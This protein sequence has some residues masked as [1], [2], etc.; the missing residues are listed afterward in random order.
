MGFQ[1]LVNQNLSQSISIPSQALD[2]ARTG[3]R[4]GERP[5]PAN[6][7]GLRGIDGISILSKSKSLS[8]YINPLTS[9]RLGETR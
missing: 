7:Y 5:V 2:W 1:Y 8:I 9:S 3:S 6:P 4:E